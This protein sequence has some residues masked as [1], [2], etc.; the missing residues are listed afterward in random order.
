[1]VARDYMTDNLSRN[2]S[3]E[4]LSTVCGL[5][6][7]HLIRS[8]AHEFGLP[9][10]AYTNQLRLLAAKQLIGREACARGHRRRLLR[11]ESPGA[12]FWSRL[13]AYTGR[14]P[15]IAPVE[16]CGQRTIE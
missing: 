15:K 11:P 7:S 1:M 12:I 16:S 4:E 2:V 5:T 9:P 10:H 8:F 13:R 3:I 14:L 6:R